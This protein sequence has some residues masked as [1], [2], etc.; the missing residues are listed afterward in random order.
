MASV[1]LKCLSFP[2]LL[3]V[4]YSADEAR[5]CAAS[6]KPAV[7]MEVGRGVVD[8]VYVCIKTRMRAAAMSALDGM[9]KK[10]AARAKLA[11]MTS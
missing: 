9:K 3:L 7:P 2:L 8:L 11:R 5:V 10:L 1:C 4:A 6:T